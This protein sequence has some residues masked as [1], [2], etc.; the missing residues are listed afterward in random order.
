MT[1]NQALPSP[2]HIL[3]GKLCRDYFITPQG[4]PVLDVLGGN[5]TYAAVGLKIWDSEQPIGLLSRV[6]IDYPQLWLDDL[7]Q[8]GFDIRGV[9]VLPEPLDVRNFY[10]YTDKVTRVTGNPIAYFSRLGL[11]LPK[12][13]LGYK[14]SPRA[15]DNRTS[16]AQGSLRRADL[17]E[18]Y[19]GAIAVHICP[20]DYMTHS[21]MPAVFRQEG[22]TTVTL[23]PNPGYMNANF[24]NDVP[25]ILTGLT[26]FIPAE[27]DIRNLFEGRSDDLWEMAEAV[28]AYGC[29]FVVIKRGERGQLLYDAA[30]KTRWE[31]PA[32]P[33][34][35]VNLT[36]VGDAFCGGFLAGYRHTYDPV[37]GM[38]YGN[39]S[40]AIVSEGS[41][42]FFALDVLPGLARARLDSLRQA[43]R[44]L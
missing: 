11:P 14:D 21:L 8:K 42:A 37:E 15:L 41:G 29:E 31:V 10:V 2:T 43:I 7:A 35:L 24:W 19:T 4:E 5:L 22:L 17:P 6:G 40:A 38:L 34:G 44:K 18:P 32:Y 13:L 27:E 39:I 16:L 23:D 20:I 9:N 12:A 26:A 28:A 25:T 1:N 3:A 33:A 36:G 30:S